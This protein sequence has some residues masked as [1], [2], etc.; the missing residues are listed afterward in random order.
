MDQDALHTLSFLTLRAT[1]G[2]W[3]LYCHITHE[4]TEA[5]DLY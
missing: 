1:Q 5:Q 3:G 4:Q 2:G